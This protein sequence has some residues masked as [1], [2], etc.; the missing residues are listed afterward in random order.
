M[1]TTSHEVVTEPTGQITVLGGHAIFEASC[2]C[3]WSVRD[4]SATVRQEVE[5]HLDGAP[6]SREEGSVSVGMLAGLALALVPIGLVFAFVA[7]L[8]GSI[9]GVIA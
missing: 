4:T 6:R 2:M 1:G 5:Y 7:A 8:L 9:A 3:G